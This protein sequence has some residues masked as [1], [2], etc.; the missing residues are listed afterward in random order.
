[1]HNPQ[2]STGN[3]CAMTALSI[4]IPILAALLI[5]GVFVYNRLIT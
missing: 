3:A 2:P 1:M 4:L 5:W